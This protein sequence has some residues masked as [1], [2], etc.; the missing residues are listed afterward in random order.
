MTWIDRL[1]RPRREASPP[2]VPSLEEVPEATY[3]H[4][5]EDNPGREDEVSI[6]FINHLQ[7]QVVELQAEVAKLKELLYGPSAD[8]ESVS[9]KEVDMRPIGGFKPR[10]VVARDIR[11]KLAKKNREAFLANEAKAK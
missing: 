11:L 4:V 3:T 7:G 9:R 8:S 6:R 1:L 2:L 5:Q 10:A